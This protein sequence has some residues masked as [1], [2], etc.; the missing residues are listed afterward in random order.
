MRCVDVCFIPDRMCV[1]ASRVDVTILLQPADEADRSIESSPTGLELQLRVLLQTNNSAWYL[2]SS[3]WAA[4][5]A[6]SS[7]T[8]SF[9]PETEPFP[10]VLLISASSAA[11]VFLV[12]VI[13]HIARTN[14]AT[15]N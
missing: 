6:P 4:A 2:S 1:L 9:A 13:A 12:A 11:F 3:P 5:V 14:S 15:P 10:L 8:G 7:L